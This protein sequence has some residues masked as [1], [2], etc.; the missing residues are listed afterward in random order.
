MPIL[1]FHI[2]MQFHKKFTT[3]WTYRKQYEDIFDGLK[4][5]SKSSML[6]YTFF[7]LRRYSIALCLIALP[8]NFL[9][10]IY[11]QLISSSLFLFYIIDSKPHKDI[12]Q[13]RI[14]V[15]NELT[16][17]ISCYWLFIFTDL[18]PDSTRRYHAG[19]ALVGLIVINLLVNVSIMSV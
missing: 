14:E 5:R 3:D 1:L 6:Y 12:K 8:D 10:Q 9:F 11:L 4:G 16:V 17:S 15:F 7:T 19:W 13:G 2:A 18:C